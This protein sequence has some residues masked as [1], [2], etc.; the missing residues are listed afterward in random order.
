MKGIF[1]K[2]SHFQTPR[3]I[4]SVLTLTLTLG[5]GQA[6]ADDPPDFCDTSPP[7]SVPALPAWVQPSANAADD[8]L[9]IVKFIDPAE[10]RTSNGTT[11]SLTEWN[12]GDAITTATAENGTFDQI[13]GEEEC[14]ELDTLLSAGEQ[15][16]GR[17]ARDLAG[18]HRLEFSTAKSAEEIAN[19]G[20]DLLALPEVELVEM[21]ARHP[22]QPPGAT[23]DLRPEQAYVPANPGANFAYANNTIGLS[24]NG[25]RVTEMSL[26]WDRFHEDLTSASIGIESG[27]SPIDFFHLPNYPDATS[28]ALQF[29]IDHGTATLGMLFAN[30]NSYGIT[31]VATDAD[32]FMYPMY[33]TNVS[34]LIDRRHVAY[35]NALVDSINDGLGNIVYFEYQDGQIAFTPA[36]TLLTMWELTRAGTDAGVVVIQAAGNGNFDLD[37]HSA[38]DKWRECGDSGAMI[39]GAGTADKNHDREPHSNFGQRVYPHGWGEAIVTLG[40]GDRFGGDTNPATGGWEEDCPYEDF[41]STQHQRYT[42]HF[43]RTSGATAMI[44][45]AATLLQEYTVSQGLSPL[46]SVD[47]RSLLTYT[48]I[49]QGSGG[50]IGPFINVEAAINDFDIADIGIETIQIGS[51]PFTTYVVNEGPRVAQ[52]VQVEIIYNPGPEPAMITPIDVPDECED[53]SYPEYCAGGCAGTLV[54]EFDRILPEQPV[55]ITFKYCPMEWTVGSFGLDVSGEVSNNGELTDD[56]LSNNTHFMNVQSASG[57]GNMQ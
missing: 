3:T 52:D 54:C 30:D 4:I 33:D 43:G 48:G 9:L 23:P 5:G 39:V 7:V 51:S 57:C 28:E 46:D 37:T 18:I 10:V 22:G 13:L 15:R 34:S 27:Q 44:A 49:P 14:T 25:I 19:L 56:D 41:E 16:T 11:Y 55:E 35:C 42:D 47:M 6:L 26:A 29:W 17:P 50:H 45:A 1:C 38:L 53:M 8:Y 32:G 40:C 21:I 12:I 36:E 2:F 31:G 24:G 20:I